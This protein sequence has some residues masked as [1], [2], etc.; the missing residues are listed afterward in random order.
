MP[1]NGSSNKFVLG[2][3]VGNLDLP[4]WR[5]HTNPLVGGVAVQELNL[6]SPKMHM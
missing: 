2:Y 4:T 5:Y 3:G 6:G 1:W